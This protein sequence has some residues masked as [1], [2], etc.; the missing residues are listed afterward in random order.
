MTVGSTEIER[1]TGGCNYIAAQLLWM[2]HLADI[3]LKEVKTITAIV[4]YISY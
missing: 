3:C 2:L 4:K 1:G